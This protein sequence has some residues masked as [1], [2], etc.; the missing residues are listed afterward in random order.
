MIFATSGYNRDNAGLGLGDFAPA[1]SAEAME[2]SISL[3]SMRGDYVILT[4][5]S[6]SDAQSRRQANV[7]DAW[8]RTHASNGWRT[9]GINFDT[10]PSLFA[11]IARRDNLD[12]QSQINVQGTAARKIIK[13]FRLENA[14]GSMLIGPDGRILAVNPPTE[15]LERIKKSKN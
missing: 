6:S 13:D 15:A 4:F 14:Y 3:E 1:L 8:V 7:Y 2:R 10:E 9:L 12:T 5:W 11:E